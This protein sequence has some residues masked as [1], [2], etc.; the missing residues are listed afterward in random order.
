[1]NDAPLAAVQVRHAVT[2]RQ[3]LR[4]FAIAAIALVVISGAVT[5]GGRGPHADERDNAADDR[6]L[7]QRS[8]PRSHPRQPGQVRRP[9]ARRPRAGAGVVE[10]TAS[11][12]RGTPG[13]RTERRTTDRT[14]KRGECD[15][16][17]APVPRDLPPLQLGAASRTDTRGCRAAAARTAGVTAARPRDRIGR[18]AARNVGAPPGRDRR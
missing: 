11:P 10:P 15:G 8:R 6:L 3:R 18:S 4:R 14:G 12:G 5:I 13:T 17:R 7:L 9:R 1:M 16:C 2:D